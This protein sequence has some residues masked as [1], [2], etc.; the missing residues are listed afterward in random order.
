MIHCIYAYNQVL[1]FQSISS[2]Y[3]NFI[4][5]QPVMN[6]VSKHIQEDH[7]AVDA[8]LHIGRYRPL[9]YS[10]T[11]IRERFSPPLEHRSV[12]PLLIASMRTGGCRKKKCQFDKLYKV[13]SVR[14]KGYDIHILA[15][16]LVSLAGLLYCW[17]KVAS[18][19][20]IAKV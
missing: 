8:M 18:I 5:T 1:K 3:K 16:I 20:P 2:H 17:V 7:S 9:Q 15:C 10:L 12:S 4:Y 14:M 11:V 6:I 13:K 19:S